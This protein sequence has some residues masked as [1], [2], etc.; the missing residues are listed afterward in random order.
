MGVPR[1]SPLSREEFKALIHLLIPLPLFLCSLPEF[2]IGGKTR[3]DSSFLMFFTLIWN[4]V[5]I[6]TLPSL[7]VGNHYSKICQST[8]LPTTTLYK[9]MKCQ[10]KKKTQIITY[11]PTNII[12]RARVYITCSVKMLWLLIFQ[13]VKL[14]TK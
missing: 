1:S 13:K 4:I 3:K 5:F 10:V 7:R 14:I 8:V 9:L 6:D 11:F 2:W 12:L